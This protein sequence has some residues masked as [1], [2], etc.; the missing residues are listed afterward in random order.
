MLSVRPPIS[1]PQTTVSPAILDELLGEISS[2]A[3]VYHKPAA[4]F[5][6]KGR[7]GAEE[8]AKRA[9]ECVCVFPHSR[10]TQQARRQLISRTSI[11]D[12]CS[13]P[14]SRKSARLRC[15]RRDSGHV[16]LV[17]LGHLTRR[18]LLSSHRF[19]CKIHQPTRRAHGPLQQRKYG[20]TCCA[21]GRTCGNGLPGAFYAKRPDTCTSTDSERDEKGWCRGGSTR[22]IMTCMKLLSS[23]Q[24]CVHEPSGYRS[25]AMTGPGR[26][27]G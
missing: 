10:L 1:L 23:R 5:V 12:R 8:M 14:A 16:R 6:G 4:T 20:R 2:L 7:L 3:S 22:S 25:L 27:P 19:G 18:H 17:N 13:R 26:G 15:G 9:A 21:A 11:A 24:I